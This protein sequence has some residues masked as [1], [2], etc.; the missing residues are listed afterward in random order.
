[1]HEH[2]EKK[3]RAMLTSRPAYALLLLL[4]LFC[5][6]GATCARALRNPF[7]QAGPS[8]PGVLTEGMSLDQVIAAVNRNAARVQSFQTTNASITVPGMPGIPL[9]RGNIAVQR[10]GRIRLQASTVLTGPE[11]DLGSGDESFWLWVRRNEPPAL[12][13]SRHD[14]FV[15]SAAQQLMPIDPAWLLDAMGLAQLS[16]SDYHEGPVPQGNG[17]LEIRSVVQTRTG[18]VTK[19]T[20]VD[21]TRAWILEQH[22]YDSTGTLLASV[23]AKSHRYYPE[24]DVSLPQKITLSLPQAKL[25][26]SI[27]LGSVQL[28]Q[29]TNNPALWTLPV[30]DGY[31]QVDLGSIRQDAAGAPAGMPVTPSAAAP[32]LYSPPVPPLGAT[33]SAP[34]LPRGV[35]K[36]PA[37]GV[38][39][40]IGWQR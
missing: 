20:V 39:V 25:K 26:L 14:Q 18:T 33:L 9:L 38:P 3:F 29:L 15:G 21:A 2:S 27:D 40:Q 37:G 17:R 28:N 31:P 16:P 5:S 12:Y 11:F 13:F 36:V 30:L 8:A 23:V 19:S 6:T 22:L 35:Q 4:T 34:V 10:P 32:P 1:M 7:A 24:A